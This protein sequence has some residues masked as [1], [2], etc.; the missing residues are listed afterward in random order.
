MHKQNSCDLI[1]SVQIYWS[2]SISCLPVVHLDSERARYWIY[3][4]IIAKPPPN[5][6]SV[7]VLLHHGPSLGSRPK[8]RGVPHAKMHVDRSCRLR[9]RCRCCHQSCRDPLHPVPCIKPLETYRP[10]NYF[11]YRQ[12]FN[13]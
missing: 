11:Y 7:S 13:F 3:L 9:R 12:D 6:V 1:R 8:W 2:V 10:S 4:G 5:A